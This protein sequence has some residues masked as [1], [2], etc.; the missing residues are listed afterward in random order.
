LK[1]FLFILLTTLNDFFLPLL[2]YIAFLCAAAVHTSY[3]WNSPSVSPQRT[4]T[5]RREMN[6]GSCSYYR[7]VAQEL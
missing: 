6:I 7:W 3:G 4:C 2:T 5:M 1:W